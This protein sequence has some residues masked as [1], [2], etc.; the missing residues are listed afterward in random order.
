MDGHAR[1]GALV[2]DLDLA[3]TTLYDTVA[4]S[5]ALLSTLLRHQR[6]TP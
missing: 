6:A 3:N 1:V 5:R 2:R 4:R